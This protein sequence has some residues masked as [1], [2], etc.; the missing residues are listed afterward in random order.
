MAWISE[1]FADLLSDKTK[2][3][4]WLTTLMK[5]GSPQLTMI[6]FNTDGKYVLINSAVGRVKDRNMRRDP[7]VAIVITDPKNP[8]R[9]IQIRGKVVEIS[10][11][12]AREHINTLAKKYTGQE[13]YT[14]GDP[15]EKR[16]IYKVLPEK[17]VEH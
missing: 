17:V 15:D 2:A 5:D 9:F 1:K 3:F 8:Y 13:R 7:R 4:A 10:T 16:V 14:S 11:Q 6:W 12:G